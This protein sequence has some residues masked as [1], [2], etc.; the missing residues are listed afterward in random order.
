MLD[1]GRHAVQ[2][3]SLQVNE[4]PLMGVIVGFALGYNAALLVHGRR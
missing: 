3:A 4:Q 1:A 2:A